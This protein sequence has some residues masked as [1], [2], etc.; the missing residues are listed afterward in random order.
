MP[1]SLA[2][3]RHVSS[4]ISVGETEDEVRTVRGRMQ[5]TNLC[6]SSDTYM[7]VGVSASGEQRER[8]GFFPSLDVLTAYNA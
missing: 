3:L 4:R 5:R 2:K 7:H 6:M 8:R 1:F